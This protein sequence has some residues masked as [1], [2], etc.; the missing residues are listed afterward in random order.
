MV[1]LAIMLAARRD[2]PLSRMMAR[3]SAKAEPA[4]APS[5]SRAASSTPVVSASAPSTDPARRA[6][7][8]IDAR[9]AAEAVRERADDQ[10]RQRHRHEEQRQR[11]LDRGVACPKCR[12]SV[13]VAGASRLTR[14]LQRRDRDKH[15]QRRLCRIG[16]A[17][18]PAVRRQFEVGIGPQALAVHG[19]EPA[20]DDQRD[21]GDGQRVGTSPQTR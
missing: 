10:L 14:S 20:A 15:H 1:T 16:C 4:P 6:R 12:A 2:W 11:E 3:E 7:S 17:V 13:G 9:A 5:S 18:M 8:R 19:V 21:A